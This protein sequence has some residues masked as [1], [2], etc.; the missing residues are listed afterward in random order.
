MWPRLSCC[1]DLQFSSCSLELNVIHTL[2]RLPP[3]AIRG[4]TKGRWG[5]GTKQKHLSGA[6]C[7]VNEGISLGC[8]ADA[9]MQSAFKPFHKHINWFQTHFR[10]SDIMNSFYK[11][12][13]P[14]IC[15]SMPIQHGIQTILRPRYEP[16]CFKKIGWWFLRWCYQTRVTN[17]C[18]LSI[19]KYSKIYNTW[20]KKRF[21]LYVNINERLFKDW[22]EFV[23]ILINNN[24]NNNSLRACDHLV[25]PSQG[26]FILYTYIDSS[27]N[28]RG[29]DFCCSVIVWRGM[30][31]RPARFSVFLSIK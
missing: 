2:Q 4:Q 26:L 23:N 9:G 29:T 14:M 12:R 1:S 18:N 13:S 3:F 8:F 22:I 10:L 27:L 24:S 19:T 15:I 31:N 11:H 5:A 17:K 7:C 6:K 20:I 30:W 28:S 25:A 16:I 21:F